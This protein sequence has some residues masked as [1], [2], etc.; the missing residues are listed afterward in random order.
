ML[1]LLL[2]GEIMKLEITHRNKYLRGMS[3]A[4]NEKPLLTKVNG[5]WSAETMLEQSSCFKN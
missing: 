3:G 1:F 4:D 2:N 5:T